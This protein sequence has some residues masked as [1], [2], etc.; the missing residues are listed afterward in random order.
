MDFFN[1]IIRQAKSDKKTIVFPEGTEERTVKAVA[2]VLEQE[3]A[4]VI[5]IGNRD[6]VLSMQPGLEF[7]G[8]QIVDH[9][10]DST[11]D[12]F[13]QTFYELRKHK[14]V[15]LDDAIKTM[16]DPVYYAT[17][18]VKKGIADGMVSG[19]IHSTADT[20]RPALQILKTAPGSKLVSSFFVMDVP[21]SSFGVDGVLVM[22]DCAL[23][24]D[25]TP[26]ELSEIAIASARSTKNFLDA[27]PKVALLSYSTMGSGDGPM[28][29]K[30][31]D[32]LKLVREKAPELQ[33]DGELQ[34]DAAIVAEVAK[35]KAPGSKVAGQA[36]TL[37]F[38]DLNSGNIGYKL[39]QRLAK[40]G[41]YGP[42]L[43]GIARPVNDLSRGCLIEDIIGVT[44]ITAVQAQKMDMEQ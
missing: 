7:S 18:M 17:M 3:I 13:A 37:I 28:V 4:D 29:D 27:T 33:V 42:I 12:D 10:T 35:L 41:A 40:A 23:V 24:I 30:V 34:L 19:A 1:K 36:N 21:G 20:L 15:T 32:A 6:E 14:G 31:R 2:H 38:P 39:V 16:E 11:F 5:L 25:P 43:Q 22:G 26:E 9:V 8:A 44:A